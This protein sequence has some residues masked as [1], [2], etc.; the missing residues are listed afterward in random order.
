MRQMGQDMKKVGYALTSKFFEN[1]ECEFFPCHELS[2]G[3]N[4][5]FCYCPLYA[6]E[7]CP[8]TGKYIEKEGRRVKV[9]SDCSFPHVP[10]NYDKV[11]AFLK[12]KM[13]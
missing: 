2:G 9:C 10:E 12:S 5:L 1:R 11:I 13:D 8:G 4:C 6:Y 7:D 3:L